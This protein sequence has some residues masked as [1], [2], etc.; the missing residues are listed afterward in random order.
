MINK[1]EFKGWDTLSK[2]LSKFDAQKAV[3][4]A[5]IELAVMVKIEAKK[6]VPVDTGKLRASIGIRPIIG[7]R[8][9]FVGKYYGAYNE[10]GTGPY[11]SIPTGW[12]AIAWQF[13]GRE[14]G[15]M[16]A[17]PY[18]IPAV[19]KAKEEADKVLTKHFNKLI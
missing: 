12:E 6:K 5:I 11:V 14:P 13:K 10:F 15:N 2:K 7:G 16:K 18:F 4:R 9:V 3:N 17:R 8:E 19:D 1:I